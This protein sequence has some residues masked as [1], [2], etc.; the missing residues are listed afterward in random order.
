LLLLGENGVG[1][2]SVLK[3]IA[4]AL[5]TP[6]A[7]KEFVPIASQ[8]VRHKQ[9]RGEVRLGFSDGS[10]VLLSF[11]RGD[12]KFSASSSPP[13]TLLVGYGPTRLPP[14]PGTNSRR[15]SRFDV[16]NLFDPWA[17]LNDAESW[18]ANP[19]S[20]PPDQFN[21]LA[22]DL[23]TL[24]PMT[25]EDRL[26][27]RN[28]R[29]YATSHGSTIPLAQL[30]DGYRSVIALATDLML[31]LS[32]SFDSMRAAEGLLLLDEI[33]VHLHPHWRMTIVNLLREVF[34]RLRVIA[35]THDPLCLQQTEPGEVF[36]LRR[37]GDS[38]VEAV[39]QDVPRG[40]RADQLLTGDWF[41]LSSTTDLETAEM[42]AEHGRLLIAEP[43]PAARRT[44]TRLEAQIRERVGHFAETSIE[45]IAQ[46]VTARFVDEE[47]IELGEAEPEERDRLT[48][49]VLEAVRRRRGQTR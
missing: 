10:D 13:P 6:D 11:Q 26:S 18:L 31:R 39:A 35:T 37:T 43:T 27:R 48:E 8:V 19:D 25:E 14:P 9:S 32:A 2:S 28:G 16:G 12:P 47:S 29:L 33:E 40:L 22:T 3:A 4:L 1:K 38:T 49:S 42:L 21:L 44:R 30:S 36:V 15:P 45:R 17:T 34:P 46:D 20:V 24:L 41:G 7:R 23:K 5:M